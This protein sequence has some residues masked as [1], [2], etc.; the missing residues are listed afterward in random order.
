[1]LFSSE[2][3]RS[4]DFDHTVMLSANVLTVLSVQVSLVMHCKHATPLV[5]PSSTQKFSTGFKRDVRFLISHYC[6]LMFWVS[7]VKGTTTRGTSE[8]F[9]H[10]FNSGRY[11]VVFYMTTILF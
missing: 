11:P 9:R 1:M 3:I 7:G 6:Y 8:I 10:L 2:S 5:A 4:C